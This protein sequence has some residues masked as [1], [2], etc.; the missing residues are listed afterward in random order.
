MSRGK[1]EKQKT[2]LGSSPADVLMARRVPVT[3]FASFGFRTLIKM[4]VRFV[5]S[6]AILMSPCFQRSVMRFTY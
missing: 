3:S 6:I 4:H 1:R 5:N 2:W